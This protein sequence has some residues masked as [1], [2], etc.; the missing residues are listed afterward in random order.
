MPRSGAG[1]A[2]ARSTAVV[3]VIVAASLVGGCSD[4]PTSEVSAPTTVTDP[5]CR[6]L[7]ALAEAWG[8]QAS[9][10]VLGDDVALRAAGEDQAADIAAAVD[11]ALATGEV[12]DEVAVDLEVVAAGGAT[13]VD[14]AVAWATGEAPDV[15]PTLPDGVVDAQRRVDGW[16]ASRCGAEVWG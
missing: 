14:A 3:A 15:A 1:R 11:A 2:L 5:V 6:H 13:Y 9:G 10:A 7:D 4:D 16:A 8:R 12:P